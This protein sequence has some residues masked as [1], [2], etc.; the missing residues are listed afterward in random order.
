MAFA[1]RSAT[2]KQLL[3][4]CL[5]LRFLQMMPYTAC[6]QPDTPPPLLC[7]NQRWF[8][9]SLCRYGIPLRMA[10]LSPMPVNDD[11][12][13]SQTLTWL[14]SNCSMVA[15]AESGPVP[16]ITVPPVRIALSCQLVSF[17]LS[18]W[19]GA[20]TA[21]RLNVL[22]VFTIPGWMISCIPTILSDDAQRS[23]CPVLT[24]PA[25]QRSRILDVEGSSYRSIG[26]LWII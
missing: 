1:H 16:Q 13:L 12:V 19:P 20:F 26:T 7:K 11:G 3:H 23:L 22:S 10:S 5:G 2:R 24:K 21:T 6:Q 4:L 18:P 15:L 17:L 9:R 14:H 25:Q 8:P